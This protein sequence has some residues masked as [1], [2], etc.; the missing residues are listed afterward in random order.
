MKVSWT[1]IKLVVILLDTP[2]AVTSTSFIIPSLEYFFA[3]NS[4]FLEDV[5][6]WEKGS[7]TSV[8]FDEE[9][10]FTMIKSLYIFLFQK[11]VLK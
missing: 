6:Y 3:G 2:H 1:Q 7:S 11:Q 4:R 8:V 5:E 9:T 10:I